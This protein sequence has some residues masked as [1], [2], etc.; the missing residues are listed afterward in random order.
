MGTFPYPLPKSSVTVGGNPIGYSTQPTTSTGE[1]STSYDTEHTSSSSQSTV[2]PTASTVATTEPQNWAPPP[3]GFKIEML[4]STVR[5]TITKEITPSGKAHRNTNE[6]R[7]ICKNIHPLSLPQLK[8]CE[9]FQSLLLLPNKTRKNEANH[10]GV[11]AVHIKASRNTK[12]GRIIIKKGV[13]ITTKGNRLISSFI[14]PE[15]QAQ[16]FFFLGCLTLGLYPLAKVTLLL[17]LDALEFAL[18]L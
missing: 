13:V 14:L 16:S 12:I 15:L 17:V 8:L 18:Q 3:Q 9:M 10:L 5:I 11:V 7:S 6:T 4:V 1:F 2:N